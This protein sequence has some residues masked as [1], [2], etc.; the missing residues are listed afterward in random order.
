MRKGVVEDGWQRFLER[1]RR[2]W[3]KLHGGELP[4]TPVNAAVVHV[5][6]VAYVAD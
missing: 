2:L 6:A 3:G 5:A 4:Q 1:L